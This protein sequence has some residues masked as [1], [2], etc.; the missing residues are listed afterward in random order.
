MKKYTRP[1]G[2]EILAG[3]PFIS[4]GIKYP[5]NWIELATPDD[6]ARVG[7]TVTEVDDPL[8]PPPSQMTFTPAQIVAAFKAWGTA[9]QVLA[10]LDEVTKAEFFTAR[11]VPADDPR[12]LAQLE[13]LGKTLDD[14]KMAIGG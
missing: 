1:D 12:L 7:I 10:S 2:T 13:A 5:A 14:L 11:A 8:P 4:D 3:Q 6:L 9:A